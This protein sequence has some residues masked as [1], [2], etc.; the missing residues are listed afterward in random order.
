MSADEAQPAPVAVAAWERHAGETVDP[1]ALRASLAAGNLPQAFHETAR[2]AGGKLAVTIDGESATYVELDEAAGRTA[3]WL[4]TRGVKLGERVILCGPNS[5]AFVIAY[6]GTLRAGAVA[7]LA[8]ADVTEREL[9]HMAGHSGAAAAFA[10]GDA[11]G[12]LAAVAKRT[13][14]DP[15]VALD[16]DAR[17]TLE[18]ASSG[19]ESL[20][21]VALDGDDVAVIGYTSGTT[22]SPKGAALSHANVLASLRGIMIGWRWA[23][24]DVLVHSLPMSHQ[25]GMA[26]LQVTLLAGS[27][28]VIQRG[29]DPAAL[30]AAIE[31]EQATVLF[32][33]PAVYERLV[34]HGGI[35]NAGAA[36]SEDRGGETPTGSGYNSLRLAT[37]GSAPLPPALWAEAAALTGSEPLERYGTTES[38]LDVSNV[39]EGP[40]KPGAVGIPLPGVEMRVVD[41]KG[42]ELDA[43]ADGEVVVRGPQVLAGYWGDKRASQESFFEG[44]WFRTGDVGRVD[45]GDGYLAITGRIKELIISGGMN[46]YP[47][48]VELVLEQHP[49]VERAA[50]VGVPSERWGE[51]VVAFVVPAGG[52]VDSQEIRDHAREL[53]APYKSPKV[54][55]ETGA[56]PFD[57]FGKLRRTELVEMAKKELD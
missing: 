9:E 51:E 1:Q 7:V 55:L 48:E 24:D 18:E 50:V 42:G 29:L 39:Y 8:G 44:G 34:A 23:E 20:D 12:R 26:G 6:L 5:L 27:R 28:A 31:R 45:P 52:R 56:L 47:R 11:H 53:L 33:V 3:A 25:H 43:G 32:S 37:S 15:I 54:V 46:V 16:Q 21:P 13:G 57:G 40:R 10:A 19:P 36:A 22:G 35:R 49:A 2:K 17:P 30:S 4:R 38:G 14:L 41:S